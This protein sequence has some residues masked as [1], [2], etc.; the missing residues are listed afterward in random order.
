MNRRFLL[1]FFLTILVLAVIFGGGAA[2]IMN[3]PTERVEWVVK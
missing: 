1:Y 3:T 2:W